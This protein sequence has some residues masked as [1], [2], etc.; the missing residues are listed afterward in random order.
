LDEKGN[1]ILIN[2]SKMT[3]EDVKRNGFDYIALSFVD[4]KGEAVRFIDYELA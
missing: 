1:V 4:N 3:W 2:G